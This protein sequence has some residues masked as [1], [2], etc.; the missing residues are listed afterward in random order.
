MGVLQRANWCGEPV[1]LGELFVLRKRSGE[2]RCVVRTH[3]FGWEL[4]LQVGAAAE[5]LLSCVCRTQ[6]E[7]FTIGEQWR[8][9][10]IEKG[11]REGAPGGIRN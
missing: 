1:H 11:W 3:Q 4:R 6:P 9:G 7:A 8:T 10:M 2:A 5:L